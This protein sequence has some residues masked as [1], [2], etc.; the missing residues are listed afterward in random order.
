MMDERSWEM[1]HRAALTGVLQDTLT[2]L[3]Y[4]GESAD[5]AKLAKEREQAIAMLRGVCDRH[6]DN[7]WPDDLHL[8]DIIEKHLARHL[9]G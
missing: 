4:A 5:V 9:R 2:R 6:G 3:G 1:G 8:A 7:D